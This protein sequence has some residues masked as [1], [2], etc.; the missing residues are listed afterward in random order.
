MDR[1]E[2]QEHIGGGQVRPGPARDGGSVAHR[3]AP[4]APARPPPGALRPRGRARPRPPRAPAPPG[5]APR[6]VVSRAQ[7]GQAYKV[8]EVA[9]GNVRCLKRIPLSKKNYESSLQEVR[10]LHGERGG[11]RAGRGAAPPPGRPSPGRPP[12]GP[13]RPRPADGPQS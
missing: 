10:L 12:P 3:P 9:T 4:L 2:V 6:P 7:Y 5:P 1:Y 11:P 8:R 13:G